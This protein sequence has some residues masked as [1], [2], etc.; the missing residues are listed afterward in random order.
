VDSKFG[1]A[2]GA[3][4]VLAGAFFLLLPLIAPERQVD[5]PV[6][7]NILAGA[8]FIL[9]GWGIIQIQRNGAS[10]PVWAGLICAAVGA[11]IMVMAGYDPDESRFHAPRWVVALTGATFVLGGLAAM[12]GYARTS[13]GRPA[14]HT[15]SY[16]FILALLLTCFAAVASW[17]AFGPGDRDF[18]GA[19]DAGTGLLPFEVGEMLGRMVFSPGALLLDVMALAAWYFLVRAIVQRQRG[20]KKPAPSKPRARRS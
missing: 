2:F 11:F 16:G 3:V 13:D 4:F 9:V 12:R 5:T 17:V 10:T 18:R 19:L 15:V 1:I 8:L 20:G 7:M 14:A 6:W